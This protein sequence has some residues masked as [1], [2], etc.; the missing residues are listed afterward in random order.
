MRVP[1]NY[2]IFL[3]LDLFPCV[4]C[5]VASCFPAKT[6]TS[7]LNLKIIH[8]FMIFY[9]I[10]QIIIKNK[11]F[12]NNFIFVY[13]QLF[14]NNVFAETHTKFMKRLKGR[15]KWDNISVVFFLV[16]MRKQLAIIF[17][18][19]IWYYHFSVLLLSKTQQILSYIVVSDVFSIS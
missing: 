16:F 13:K 6:T 3:I 1:T 15:L 12:E 17:K 4:R 5:E 14:K 7:H 19:F 9:R 10:M 2:G 18:L 8:L 11:Y